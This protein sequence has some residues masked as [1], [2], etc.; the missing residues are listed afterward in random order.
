MSNIASNAQDA[1]A[2]AQERI[3]DAPLRA[4]AL[5]QP[6]LLERRSVLIDTEFTHS[7]KPGLGDTV[8]EQIQS[9]IAMAEQFATEHNG[10][11]K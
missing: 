1:R 5:E 9:R 7:G 10:K 3:L 4:L 8:H 11:A 2:L 6:S